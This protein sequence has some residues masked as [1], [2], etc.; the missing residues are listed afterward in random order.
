LESGA[1][2]PG[3]DLGKDVG[4]LESTGYAFIGGD[5][6]SQDSFDVEDEDGQRQFTTVKLIREDVEDIL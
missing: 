2:L 4:G 1:N 3:L 5:P 6:D